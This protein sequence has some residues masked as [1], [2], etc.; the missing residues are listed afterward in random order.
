[1]QEAWIVSMART[2]VG[3]APRGT[4]RNTRPDD[5]AAAVIQEVLG[6]VRRGYDRG[7]YGKHEPGSDGR[8]SLF[9]QSDAR[10]NLSRRLPQYGAHSRKSCP[11]VSDHTRTAG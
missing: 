6:R 5:M 8:A 9:S 1:M 7:R 11:Q 10:R 3:K 4:L 2:A